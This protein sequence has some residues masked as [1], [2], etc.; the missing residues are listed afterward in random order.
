MV[1][2]DAFVKKS[3]F[4]CSLGDRTSPCCLG[5]KLDNVH[6]V[7]YLYPKSSI[8]M[9]FV[10]ILAC[11][12]W[13]SISHFVLWFPCS[14]C[15]C[16]N[17]PPKNNGRTEPR[18]KSTCSKYVLTQKISHI[19][20]PRCLHWGLRPWAGIMLTMKTQNSD[21]LNFAESAWKCCAKLHTYRWVLV[22]YLLCSLV[23]PLV[24][25]TSSSLPVE[26]RVTA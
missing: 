18:S 3:P 21:A 26:T 25:Q 12:N 6:M 17:I 7:T 8:V 11:W 10:C 5:Y 19:N 13:Q 15:I 2:C 14:D 20:I 9:D 4:L 24:G 1:G 23:E 16:H 22:Y